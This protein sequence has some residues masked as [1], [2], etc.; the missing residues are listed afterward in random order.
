MPDNFCDMD[1]ITTDHLNKVKT[2][3]LVHSGFLHN[4]QQ[5]TKEG[6][7]YIDPGTT[8]N[9]LSNFSIS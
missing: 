2:S 4:V 7:M 1:T 5:L 6:Y 8:L 3:L 9:F